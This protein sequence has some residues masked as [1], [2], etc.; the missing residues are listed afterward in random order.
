[1]YWEVTSCNMH[2]SP[3]RLLSALLDTQIQMFSKGMEIRGQ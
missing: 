1:M 2:L 3:K